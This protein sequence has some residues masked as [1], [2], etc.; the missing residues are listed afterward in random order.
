MSTGTIRELMTDLKLT[1]MKEYYEKKILE[2][3]GTGLN[4]DEILDQ[5]L[6]AESDHREM[7]R[8]EARVK[9]SKLK[10]TASFEDFDFTAKRSLSKAEAREIYSLEWLDAGRPLVLIG[11]TG[12][13]KTYLAHATGLQACANKKSVLFLSF[14][15]FLIPSTMTDDSPAAPAPPTSA[16]PS[17]M[18]GTARSA[19]STRA[20]MSAAAAIKMPTIARPASALE[21]IAAIRSHRRTS[22]VFSSRRIRDRPCR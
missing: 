1:G 17:A 7:K 5:L 6:Q 15:H 14:S 12:V 18:S 9:N 3:K 10:A 13:G 20:I 2:L 8:S 11:E 4:S 22:A 16:I 19:G 21:V